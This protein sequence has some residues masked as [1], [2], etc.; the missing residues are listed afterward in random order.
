MLELFISEVEE[1]T[2][3]LLPI[4]TRILS[5]R[6]LYQA[7]S[8][9]VGRQE[10]GFDGQEQQYYLAELTNNDA[11]IRYDASHEFCDARWLAPASYD[12][13]LDRSHETRSLHFKSFSI[14]SVCMELQRPQ[15]MH[16]FC[17]TCSLKWIE[18]FSLPFY[19]PTFRHF[20]GF[21]GLALALIGGVTGYLP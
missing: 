10:N 15:P 17:L 4:D 13:P 21:V 7:T 6:G 14:F 20:L 1:E 18:G 9:P 8:S 12:L 11:V 19:G 3:G 2:S 16:E 5:S